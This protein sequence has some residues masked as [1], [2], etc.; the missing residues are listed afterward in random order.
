MEVKRTGGG[1]M[2]WGNAYKTEFLKMQY[3][4]QLKQFRKQTQQQSCYAIQ[5]DN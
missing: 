3:F 1:E 5:K 4:R 2:G